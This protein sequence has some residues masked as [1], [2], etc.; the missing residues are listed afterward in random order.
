M[1]TVRSGPPWEREMEYVLSAA[2]RALSFE[3]YMAGGVWEKGVFSSGAGAQSR[4]PC[5]LC[6]L[7]ILAHCSAPLLQCYLSHISFAFA[8]FFLWDERREGK[9]GVGG[10]FVGEEAA[11]AE[12]E[13]REFRAL[14]SPRTTTTTPCHFFVIFAPNSNGNCKGSSDRKRGMHSGLHQRRVRIPGND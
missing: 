14:N 12:R 6:S 3:V 9:R 8:F 5:V 2:G 11:M 10:L 1:M 7:S 4:T 13:S